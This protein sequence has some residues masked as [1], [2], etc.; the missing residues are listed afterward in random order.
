MDH[1][2]RTTWKAR[3]LIGRN[4]YGDR[5]FAVVKLHYQRSRPGTQTINHLY[6]PYS[7]TTASF[8]GDW[9]RKH[10]S[11]MT[12]CGMLTSRE[13]PLV[14]QKP[15]ETGGWTHAKVAELERLALRWHMND[16]SAGC[17]HQPNDHSATWLGKYPD[18]GWETWEW[19]VCTESGYKW[20]SAWLVDP[21]PV[22]QVARIKA[23][24][25]PDEVVNIERPYPTLRF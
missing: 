8:T 18:K 2:T 14:I 25:S 13:Y 1:T 12:G 3:A 16:M 9:Y 23:L 21:I 15:N 22:E 24:F 11:H 19:P 4:T 7:Y 5:V 17:A 20:G 10:S 6:A